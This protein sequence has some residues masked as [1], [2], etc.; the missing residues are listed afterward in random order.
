VVRYWLMSVVEAPGFEPN[1]EVDEVRWVS[2]ED[3]LDL[4]TYDRDK[5][6]VV[7][8]AAA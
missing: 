4:L 8:A 7:A 5:G 1:S 6:V 2:P 3:A